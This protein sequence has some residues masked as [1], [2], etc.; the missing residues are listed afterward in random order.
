MDT[1][2]PHHSHEYQI[3]SMDSEVVSSERT[4][5]FA[6]AP[7]S[8]PFAFCLRR[9]VE[10]RTKLFL[11]RAYIFPLNLV[12][13]NKLNECNWCIRLSLVVLQST[14]RTHTQLNRLTN[15]AVYVSQNLAVWEMFEI[16]KFCHWKLIRLECLS[17]FKMQQA[18]FPTPEVVSV[19]LGR[20]VLIK[21]AKRRLVSYMG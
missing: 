10:I 2:H 13:S 15:M 12:V 3:Q 14:I 8:S 16:E 18:S 19:S 20:S 7:P 5:C 6:I 17:D 9:I 11:H 4:Y 21:D 1:P